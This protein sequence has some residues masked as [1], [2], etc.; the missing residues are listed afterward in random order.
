MDKPRG[1]RVGTWL[2]RSYLN[3]IG[4]G[5][6]HVVRTIHGLGAFALIT[7]GVTV[8]KF[9]QSTRVIHP[10]VL[11][12]IHRAGLRLLPMVSF[13]AVALGLV[14]IGQSVSL[15]NKYGA[16]AQNY[17]GI[18]MVA[19]VVRELGPLVTALLVLARVGTAIVI[20]LSTQRALGEV[21]ALEALG[22]DPIHYLV[23]PRVW[24]LAVSIFSLTVYFILI[25]LVSGY[26]FAFVQDVP[27]KPGEYFEQLASS[28]IWEDFLLLALKTFAFGICIAI[29][30]C[31]QGLAH[32]VR[33]EDISNVSTNAVVES[34]IACMLID[35]FFIIIYLIITRI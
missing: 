10:L 26:V 21:E 34:V 19:V 28:L 20:D 16:G 7:L 8:T 15:L 2:A 27:V 24:G 11:S 35:A 29:I 22:I 6:L 18:V 23:V 5:I 30:T 13:M 31:Y 25:S 9:G 3:L 1:E 17:A 12:Q 32:P 14:I 4:R 33:L